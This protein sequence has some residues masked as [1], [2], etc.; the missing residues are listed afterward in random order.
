MATHS[1]HLVTSYAPVVR[2]LLLVASRDE[3]WELEVRHAHVGGLLSDCEAET[4]QFL[5]R[6]ELADVLGVL[7]DR[8]GPAGALRVR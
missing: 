6:D 4:F 7:P 3:G 1:V 2:A 8:W 5:T